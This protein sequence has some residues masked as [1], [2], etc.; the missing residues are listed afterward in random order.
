MMG[1]WSQL[2]NKS[3]QILLIEKC[4]ENICLYW[5]E[6][7]LQTKERAR[8]IMIRSSHSHSQGQSLKSYQTLH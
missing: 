4:R 1:D 7:P 8:G 3:A 2:E 6:E 5:K